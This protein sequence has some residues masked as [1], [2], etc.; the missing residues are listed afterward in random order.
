MIALRRP[1]RLRLF[2]ALW[3]A[4]AQREPLAELARA[5]VPSG[6]RAT[7]AVNLHLTL[8][9]LGSYPESRLPDLLAA[10]GDVRAPAL[11]LQLDRLGWWARPQVTWAAPSAPPEAL[12]G[13]VQ[14][15]QSAQV[16]CGLSPETRPWRPHVTLVHRARRPPTRNS[17]PPLAWPVADFVLACSE[18]DDEGPRYR[19]LQRWC[20]EGGTTAVG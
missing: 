1:G 10:A 15:L 7:R 20:L 18:R 11:T 16:R 3:P 4:A 19:V 14:D 6:G 2:F 17:M 13:L 5:L 8:A 9:F 12:R